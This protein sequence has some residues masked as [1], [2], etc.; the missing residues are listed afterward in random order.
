MQILRFKYVWEPFSHLK[1]E[2]ASECGIGMDCPEE[3]KVESGK[4]YSSAAPRIYYPHGRRA[5]LVVI[6]AAIFK[7][8]R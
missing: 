3:G 2:N 5:V 1:C 4:T 8:E 7:F 6:F